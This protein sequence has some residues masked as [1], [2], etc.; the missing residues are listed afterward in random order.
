ME[1][2]MQ[3]MILTV[4]DRDRSIELYTGIF[5]FPLASRREQ[6]AVFQINNANRSQVLVLREDRHA[7]R[8]RRGTAGAKI[9]E[10]EVASPEELTEVEERLAERHANVRQLQRDLSET[11]FS[12]HP[13]LNS[14]AVSAG[15]AG[16]PTQISEWLDPDE[17]IEELA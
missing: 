7:M 16:R 11:V 10:F 3:S 6:V 15:L 14:V 2:T 9:F 17:I 12:N 5:C 13:G 4:S 1:V 8:P